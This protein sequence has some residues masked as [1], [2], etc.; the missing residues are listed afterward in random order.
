MRDH[1]MTTLTGPEVEHARRELAAS[2]A[3]TRPG[4]P[5][6]VPIWPPPSTLIWLQVGGVRRR[7]FYS[8]LARVGVRWFGC[9]GR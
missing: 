6:R 3:L 7:E 8:D 4:S 2:L 5:A 1:D 9:R